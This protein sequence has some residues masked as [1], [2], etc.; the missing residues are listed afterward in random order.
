MMVVLVFESPNEDHCSS[1]RFSVL[2]GQKIGEF[3]GRE[4]SREF[5]ARITL[6]MVKIE[7]EK[8]DGNRVRA[9][10]KAKLREGDMIVVQT[11]GLEEHLAERASQARASQDVRA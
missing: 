10:R 1:T 9:N 5:S 6:P 7:I 11:Q 4:L 3:A 2:E 8:A